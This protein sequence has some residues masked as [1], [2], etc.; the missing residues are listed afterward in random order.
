MR[1]GP[2]PL[3]VAVALL[4]MMGATAG[5]ADELDFLLTPADGADAASAPQATATSPDAEEPAATLPV[6]PLRPEPDQTPPP[7]RS[8]GRVIEEIVV[9]AQKTEQSLQDVPI[10]VSALGGEQIKD[11]AVTEA[12]E[13][14]QY[15]PNVKFSQG[16][17]LIPT[18][19]IRG[20]GSPPLGRNLEPSV[21]LSIDDVFYGRSTFSADGIFDVDRVEVLRGPQGTLFGKNTIAGVLNFS[22][23]PPSF[24]PNGFVTVAAGSRAE[25]RIEGGIGLGLIDDVLAARLSFRARDRELGM[26]NTTRDEQGQ[27]ED[28][29]GRI[30]L[31]W[32]VTDSLTADLNA[33]VASARSRGM[34]FELQH[35]SERS[36]ARYRQVD[37][38]TEAEAFNGRQ[39]FN[40]EVFSDR[41]SHGVAL[42]LNQFIGTAGPLE[43]LDL[44]LILAEAQVETPYLIDTDFSP[45]DAQSLGSDGPERYRQRSFELRATAMTPGPF[46]LGGDMRWIGGVY[47]LESSSRVSQLSTVNI[48]GVIDLVLAGA[49]FAGQVPTLPDDLRALLDQLGLPSD[50]GDLPGPVQIVPEAQ[51]NEIGINRTD[52]DSRTLA[53]FFQTTWELTERLGVTLGYRYGQ[54]R[55]QG[56]QSSQCQNRPVCTALSIFAGQRNFSSATTRDETERSP[57]LAVSYAFSDAVTGFANITKGFKSG[58]Y[59]GPLLAPENLE[60]GPESALSYEAGVKTRLL[61][62]SLVLNAAVYRVEFDDLQVN[63]FDGTNISTINA[64]SAVSQGL[65]IDWQWLPPLEWLTLAGSFGLTDVAYGSFPCGPAIAGDTDTS[66]ECNPDGTPRPPPTQDLSGRETPFTPKMTASFTP[67]IRFPLWPR[68]NLGGIFGVDVLYQGEQYLDADLDPQSFQKATT[69]VNARL[70]IGPAGRRWSI[71][72]NAKNLTGVRERALVIDQPVIAGNYVTIAL[73]DE[74]L[75][76]LDLRYNFGN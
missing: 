55:K 50:I 6:T 9:T 44:H 75:Y 69:K 66:P 19:N 17:S 33:F 60:Y 48:N 24:D 68:R 67:S 12:Q 63:L 11:A 40:E 32:L 3:R 72:F 39:S 16:A 35:A 73:P 25:K 52:V 61:D 37:P 27:I 31:R 46:G 45:I 70:G 15:M 7:S 57:K 53:L 14:F 8:G 21:G 22:T 51:A 38:E 26:Y 43:D 47:G 49:S 5:V 65:E 34:G 13:L 56:M 64:A 29:A 59:S 76:A 41:D 36:L 18:V 71:L 28:I 58:G 20:F 54:E 30:K 1:S 10:S 2:G 74:P 4:L 23:A 42:K 62:G